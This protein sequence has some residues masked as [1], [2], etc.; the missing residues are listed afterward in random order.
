MGK[1]VFIVIAILVVIALIIGGIYFTRN[2]N[3]ENQ[4]TNIAQEDQNIADGNNET[5]TEAENAV[6]ENVAAEENGQNT[7]EQGSNIL[8]AYYSYSGNTENFAN[9]ISEEVGGDLFEIQRLDAYSDLYTEAEA[10]INNGER[11]ALASMPENVE[12]YDTIFI[13]YPIWWDRAPAMINT[14][15]GNI[16]LT[17]KTVIPFCTSSSDGIEGSMTDIRNSAQGAN[18]L[19]GLRISGGSA[20]SNRSEIQTWL[21][22]IGY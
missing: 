19:E 9:V 14:F 10:E 11:P 16:D 6:T 21:N 15:L 12:Q 5:N 8:V 20:E 18:I 2:N 4:N 3:T 13:G 17:G 7:T 1:K 22:G